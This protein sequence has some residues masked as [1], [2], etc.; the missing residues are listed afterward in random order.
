[1]QTEYDNETIQKIKSIFPE[2]EYMIVIENLVIKISKKE[3]K[4]EC[5]SFIIEDT[6]I[7]IYNLDRCDD[8]RGP[9]LLTNIF[10]LAQQLTNIEYIKLSDFS[11]ISIYTNDISLSIIKILTTGHSWYN[12]I[13]YKSTDYKNEKKENK[14]IIETQYNDFIG[15]VFE[16]LITKYLH[17]IDK[18]ITF[19]ENLDRII[20]ENPENDSKNKL[21]KTIETKIRELKENKD[22]YILERKEEIKQL[23]DNSILL[24]PDVDVDSTVQLYFNNILSKISKD[25][26]SKGS[27]DPELIKQCKWLSNFINMIEMSGILTYNSNLKKYLKLESTIESTTIQNKYLKYKQKY[28]NLKNQLG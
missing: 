10:N 14:I 23:K 1:M 12:S 25:I 26:E 9:Q 27:N 5:I 7:H 24:F 4:S 17:E 3:S 18:N 13:G 28:L 2:T 8:I 19:K 20:L 16:L 22:K 11:Q 21:I 15:I 6:Y